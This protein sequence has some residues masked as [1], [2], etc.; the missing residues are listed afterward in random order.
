MTLG[1]TQPLTEMS[2][3]NLPAVK[4]G[5]RA[6]LTTL[7]P[8][9][10]RLSRENVEASMSHNPKLGGPGT[11]IYILQEQGGPAITPGT[12]F[13]FRRLLR[14][15]GLRW[16]YSDQPPQRTDTYFHTLSFAGQ[17]DFH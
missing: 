7:P 13:P 10:N 17:L 4:G 2:T 9:V 5:R 1:S 12:G 11:C 16:R 6:R 8:S 14:L 15:A 3:R